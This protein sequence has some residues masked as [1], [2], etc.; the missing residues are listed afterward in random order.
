MKLVAETRV[1]SVCLNQLERGENVEIFIG[2]GSGVQ[3]CLHQGEACVFPEI[4]FI[5]TEIFYC[6]VNRRIFKGDN[7]QIFCEWEV[8]IDL[9]YI[10]TF[11]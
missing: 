10:W 3:L 8:L 6:C 11:R 1:A 9:L 4:K 2:S 7:S 5:K